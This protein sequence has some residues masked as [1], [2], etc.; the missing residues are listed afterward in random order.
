LE[1]KL[2]KKYG[3]KIRRLEEQVRALSKNVK[4]GGVGGYKI[5]G[6]VYNGRKEVP[7][8]YV[9]KF[10]L[11]KEDASDAKTHKQG[12]SRPITHRAKK[13]DTLGSH[14]RL[15]A[16]PK[17]KIFKVINKGKSSKL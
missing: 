3:G 2:S 14:G 6:K 10:L 16:K 1:K 13:L 17:E 12:I 15:I 8:K 9:T 11:N 7:K 4:R 5:K